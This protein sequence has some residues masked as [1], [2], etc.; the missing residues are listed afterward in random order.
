[1][2]YFLGVDLGTSSLK[3]LIGNEL[4]EIIGS[5]SHSFKVNTNSENYSEQDPYIWINAFN[6]SLSDILDQFPNLK[7]ENL[8]ISFS[9]QMHSLVLIDSNGIP[10]RPAILWNDGRT[11]EEVSHL[12]KFY[13]EHLLSIEKN[14]ALEGFTLPKLLWVKDKEP[15]I[16]SKV[17]KFMMPKDYLIYYL[18]GNVFTEPSDASGTIAYDIL[19]NKWDTSLLNQLG[20]EPNICPNILDSFGLAG[21]MKQEI[22]EL[23]GLENSVEII[24]GGADNACGALGAIDNKLDQGTISVG[25][26]G[27]I[28]Y[29]DLQNNLE[30]LGKY[31][32]FNSLIS[33]ERYKMGVTLSAGYSLEWFKNIICEDSLFEDFTKLAEKSPI[34]S[35]GIQ[36]HPYLFGERSPFFN[37][38]LSASFMFLKSFHKKEDLIRAVM[39]G[40][41]FSL[42]NVYDSMGESKKEFRI[43]GGV[44]K[45]PFWIQIFADVFDVK[46]EV[47]RL[48]EGPAYGALL[49]GVYYFNNQSV[50]EKWLK[51][52]PV[53]EEYFPI[54]ENVELYKTYYDRFKVT[55]QKINQDEK[56]TYNQK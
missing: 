41:T 26:S 45:N 2:S 52:N 24:M 4:G 42:K 17:Y 16:W 46:M 12:K 49:C 28:L 31:H 3:I 6:L 29:Y 13:S 18:T 37:P 15:D 35:R 20:I 32:Y 33:E 47:L 1:M 36:F 53:E 54:E 30:N 10:L 19:K 38:L 44:A 25:T 48:D 7:E 14:I 40:I 22:K 50:T 27:V 51:S 34:G 5:S 21:N 9:G 23:F 43:L 56:N 11:L 8:I 39:E 55:T